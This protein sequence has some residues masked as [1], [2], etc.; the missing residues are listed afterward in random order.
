MSLL[1]QLAQSSYNT[2]FSYSTNT[3][4]VDSGVAL[5]VLGTFFV[6]FLVIAV[7]VYVVHAIFLGKIFKKAGVEAW[8]AWVPIYNSWVI[9]ELGGQKGIWAVLA[10][11]P[12]VN[13]VSVV[14]LI[15]AMYQIGLNFGKEAWFVLLAIFLPLVWLIWLAI[16][17][18]KWKGVAAAAPAGQAPTFQPPVPPAAV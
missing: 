8:K 18:S 17:D 7:V 5:A 9:L 12:I 13:I 1:A 16:D 11:V 6:T 4:N 3:D 15:I 14:F 10:I 2:D